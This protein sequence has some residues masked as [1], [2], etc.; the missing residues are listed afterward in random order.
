MTFADWYDMCKTFMSLNI[1]MTQAEFL[2]SNHS[3]GVLSS[4]TTIQRQYFGRKL[5]SYK[6]GTLQKYIK[7][8]RYK[9]QKFTD[10]FFQ[11]HMRILFPFILTKNIH[12]FLFLMRTRIFTLLYIGGTYARLVY[13]WYKNVFY[14]IV[15]LIV[16]L[17]AND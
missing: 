3:N 10:E 13:T 6:V 1:K 8:F 4:C 12:K 2:R 11:L 15:V 14:M 9:K 7:P 17:A 5:T 16:Y